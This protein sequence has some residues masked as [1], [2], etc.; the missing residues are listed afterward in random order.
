MTSPDSAYHHVA[1][2]SS[3][4]TP[5]R[6]MFSTVAMSFISEEVACRGTLYRP[7]CPNDPALIVTASGLPGRSSII[8]S[9]YAERLANA[10]YA[11]FHF[12][13]RHMG[14][15]D[16]TPRNHIDP[17]AQRDDWEAALAG[18]RARADVDTTRLILCGV[19]L[20]CGVAASVAANN[21]DVDAMIGITPIRSGRS[22]FDSHSRRYRLRGLIRGIRDRVQSL[23]TSPH[24]VPVY[25]T[26]E[27][28]LIDAP[29]S[30]PSNSI[31]QSQ[32][33]A[34]DISTPARSFLALSRDAVKSPVTV[35][36]VLIDKTSESGDLIKP[37]SS[38]TD[39]MPNATT[40]ELSFSH[41]ELCNQ[42]A[43]DTVVA[44]IDAFL[45]SNLDV[46]VT[47]TD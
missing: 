33:N 3:V 13:V 2:V 46:N 19:D 17:A 25:D 32:R 4:T 37:I 47:D 22:F 7:D 42:P 10:G 44:H 12:D 18:L 34:E 21:S 9:L 40:I 27:F 43:A 11:L 31:A 20:G 35:P 39:D 16:G 1:D 45:S 15:S 8:S 26:N 6:Y 38:M 29:A 5:S 23:L 30:Y 14:E 24:T 28:A 41:A 36:T